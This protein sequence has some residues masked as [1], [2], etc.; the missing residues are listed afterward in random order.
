MNKNLR[1]STLS[2]SLLSSAVALVALGSPAVA[3]NRPAS[4]SGLDALDEGR[5][6]ESLAGLG[7]EDLLDRSFEVG[8]VPEAQRAGMRALISLNRLVNQDM[9]KLN[10]KQRK[11]IVAKVTSGLGQAMGNMK[12]PKQLMNLGGKLYA[13][14]V[15]S[16]VTL[17][18]YW[19]EDTNTQAQARAA[20]D[21]VVKI[22]EKAE[23]EANAQMN[24]LANTITNAGDP[25]LNQLTALQNMVTTIGYT[26][27]SS[28]YAVVLTLDK[29][30]PERAKTADKVIEFLKQYDDPSSSI[31][32]TVKNQIGKLL[33]AKGDTAGA[34][35]MFKSLF[36]GK[37]V[38]PAPSA[39]DQNDARFFYAVADLIAK[40]PDDA[41]K[42]LA[43]AKT[44]QDANLTA[45]ADHQI[46]ADADE[47][48]RARIAW[49]RAELATS[50][51]DKAK[52]NDQASTT[53]TALMKSNPGL[54]TLILGQLVARLPADAD[55]KKLDPLLLQALIE[56]AR[57]EYVKDKKDPF[58][59]AA[60]EKGIAAAKEI[61]ARKGQAGVD[62]DAVNSA[63]LVLPYFA[64]KIDQPKVAAAAFLDYAQSPGIDPTKAED[65]WQ[66]A[67][68][69]IV[70]DFKAPNSTDPDVPA[71]YD[72]ALTMGVNPPLN[73]K[74]LAY[75]YARRIQGQLIGITDPAKYV[76]S[77]DQV[78]K[79]LKQVTPDS[80]SALNAKYWLSVA[81][82]AKLDKD[83]KLTASEKATLLADIQK[84]CEQVTSGAKAELAK[85]PNEA[86]KRV[87]IQMEVRTPLLAASL[88]QSQQKDPKLALKILEGYEATVKG[89]PNEDLLIGD[90]QQTRVFANMD[91]GESVKATDVL[92]EFLKKNP[93]EGI[94]MVKRLFKRLDAEFSDA[95]KSKD[96]E[97]QKDLAPR[98]ALL[99]GFLAKWALENPDPKVKEIAYEY[100]SLDA[101][102][103]L[104]AAR[105]ETD[106]AKKKALLEATQKAFDDLIAQ[107]KGAANPTVAF[108]WALTSYELG[109]YEKARDGLFKLLS[110]R[111]LGAPK[112]P[113]RVTGDMQDN[114]MYWEGRYKLLRAN[115]EVAK[116]KGDAALMKQIT[117]ELR[118]VYTQ[119]G[120]DTGGEKWR[121]EFEKLRSE[122]DPTIPADE[123]TAPAATQPATAP[124]GPVID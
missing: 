66:R 54:K 57:T 117:D 91:A 102:S 19:G 79:Y 48:L 13:I 116:A 63:L 56:K 101:E 8:K 82:N 118:L 108:N 1:L 97:K 67:M 77:N 109:N 115:V 27:E 107:P 93:T 20:A 39:F 7:L 23:V 29:A 44:W 26:K 95:V 59:K 5:V 55:L 24:T 74:E 92:V 18:E 3:Q 64:Q 89:L 78:I 86:R 84:I 6:R 87:L 41:E 105:L 103:K 40:K 124:S 31:Q 46:A 69:I 106:P 49:L 90:A 22:Y 34:Q 61:L 113:D 53:L 81:L 68:G 4:G 111:Q 73:H 52:F 70:G 12:D 76:E 11:D 122:L 123:S 71:L 119:N 65:A 17:L 28:K 38:Q 10:A 36:E 25:R 35:A 32:P 43:E 114:P 88:A 16:Y 110:K 58:D 33:L 30:D 42:H 120:K 51:A 72:R 96:V 83:T 21:S 99:T 112:M 121:D 9:S 62:K 94:E 100:Q 50:P 45:K 85:N 47:V 80:P 104:I 37:D 14:G 75:T 15:A 60:V 98:R 2:L